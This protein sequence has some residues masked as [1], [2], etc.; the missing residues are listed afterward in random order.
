MGSCMRMRI[1][2]ALEKTA[3]TR[4]LEFMRAPFGG[5][6]L[7]PP[8]GFTA[9]QIAENAEVSIR[10]ARRVLRGL[11]DDGCVEQSGRFWRVR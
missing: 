4:V 5:I 1:C 9:A 6:W 7:G 2:Q 3:R 8:G 11:L 10:H